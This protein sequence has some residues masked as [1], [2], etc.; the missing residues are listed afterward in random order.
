MHNMA[1]VEIVPIV[2]VGVTYCTDCPITEMKISLKFHLSIA[3]ETLLLCI[4]KA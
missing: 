2:L 1:R 4:R 3:I